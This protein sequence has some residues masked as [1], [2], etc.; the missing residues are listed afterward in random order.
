[1]VRSKCTVRAT[2]M[3]FKTIASKSAALL[4]SE[5][6]STGGFTLEQLMELAGLSVA[7]AIFH[8]TPPPGKVLVLVGPGNNGGDGLVAARHLKLFG[9]DLAYYYPKK[10]E[11]EPHYAKLVKEL[12]D[13]KVTELKA[14]E[15]TK[16]YMHQVDLIVDALFGFSFKPPLREPFGEVLTALK[17][18]REKAIICSIDVPLGWDV[19][20][21]PI[22][23]EIN[24]D[25]QMLVSLSA[26]KPCSLKYHG[27]HWLGGR[28]IS[29]E[30]AKKYGIETV[31]SRYR[32]C[33]QVVR[34]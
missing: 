12:E 27:Y 7:Q 30:I 28:F 8:Q 3:T 33:D 16:R 22:D 15:D 2:A 32:G 29:P 25:P 24:F 34:L 17:A 9:Y 20:N 18:A 11:R 10:L 13:L 19:D 6:M 5:L 31:T 4:D 21:G 14:L 1:M 23:E 26:P